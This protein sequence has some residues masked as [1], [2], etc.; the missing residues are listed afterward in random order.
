[1]NKLH[2]HPFLLKKYLSFANVLSGVQ[3]F[4]LCFATFEGEFWLGYLL[5]SSFISSILSNIALGQISPALYSFSLFFTILFKP[6]AMGT[7]LILFIL[8]T[9][10]LL[11]LFANVN[12]YVSLEISEVL[13]LCFCGSQTT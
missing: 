10:V 12:S 13:G 5:T 9:P 11:T 8:T 1:M 4:C 7:K 3:L 2:E 6:W